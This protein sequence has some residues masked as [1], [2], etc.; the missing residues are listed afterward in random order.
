MGDGAIESIRSPLEWDFEATANRM[1]VVRK[2]SLDSIRASGSRLGAVATIQLR[3]L[4]VSIP[5][6]IVR[7]IGV[8]TICGGLMGSSAAEMR[9]VSR[10]RRIGNIG[11]RMKA[12]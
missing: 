10:R 6:S 1:P 12:S 5:G 3:R 7:D 8:G 11:R 9:L 2:I 4:S